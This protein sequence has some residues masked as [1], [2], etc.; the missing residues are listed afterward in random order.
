MSPRMK[1]SMDRVG[2]RL[3]PPRPRIPRPRRTRPGSIGRL[4]WPRFTGEASGNRAMAWAPLGHS[5]PRP[6]LRRPSNPTR[7][8]LPLPQP[9]QPFAA[10]VPA[11]LVLAETTVYNSRGEERNRK[12]AK[13][14]YGAFTFLNVFMYFEARRI[15]AGPEPKAAKAPADHIDR[16]KGSQQ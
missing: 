16:E 12:Y 1:A 2:Q 11:A 7:G 9:C 3:P 10:Y 13:P 14:A 6:S 5:P 8:R 15:K 4:G